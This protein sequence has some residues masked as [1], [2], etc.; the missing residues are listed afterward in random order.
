MSVE[1]EVVVETETDTTEEVV[2]TDEVEETTTEVET[3]DKPQYTE[4]EKKQF[5]RAKLAEAENK[6]LKTE[7]EAAKKKPQTPEKQ[8]GE[9]TFKDTFSLVQA[10]VHADDV[11]RVVK[12][13]KDEGL[14]VSEALK[15]DELKAILSVRVEHRKTAEV[16]NTTGSKRTTAKVSDEQLVE[17]AERGE[18]VDPELLADARMNLKK[19]K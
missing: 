9:V 15:N 17:K 6:R 8:G 10:N 7:L 13:A 11:D 1:D 3:E 19:K 18:D 16:A 5:E 14:T 4:F 2:N 12:F